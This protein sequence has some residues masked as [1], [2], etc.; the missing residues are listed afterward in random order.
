MER[1]EE[2]D[3]LPEDAPAEEVVD[4]APGEA[5]EDARTSAGAADESDPEQATGQPENAG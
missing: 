1:M 5:R 3:Q 4:D 2:S